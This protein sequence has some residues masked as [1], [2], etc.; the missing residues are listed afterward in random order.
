[1]DIHVSRAEEEDGSARASFTSFSLAYC[2]E[3]ELD[4]IRAKKYSRIKRDRAPRYTTEYTPPPLPPTPSSRKRSRRG[5][6]L[7]PQINSLPAGS[8]ALFFATVFLSTLLPFVG[9]FLVYLTSR[10][11]WTSHATR[12]GSRTGLGLGLFHA[13]AMMFYI[14]ALLPSVFAASSSVPL[15]LFL[16]W[17]AFIGL[18]LGWRLS[19]DAGREYMWVKTEE[20]VLRQACVNLG[21]AAASSVT[22]DDEDAEDIEAGYRYIEGTDIRVRDLRKILAKAR[23]ARL[24]R[25]LRAAGF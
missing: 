21:V 8:S 10:G 16:V 9:F 1:M 13:G 11:R 18:P 12:L 4:P 17:T 6:A 15:I 23:D 3:L 25:S 19:L 24:A 22:A 14:P 20:R 2:T 5:L 7:K